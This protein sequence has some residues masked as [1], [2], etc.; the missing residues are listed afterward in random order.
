MPRLPREGALDSLFKAAGSVD[1]LDVPSGARPAA[2]ETRSAALL[3]KSRQPGAAEPQLNR[4]GRTALERELS[5]LPRPGRAPARHQ[6]LAERLAV[7]L[8]GALLR[9]H[10]RP[11]GGR[12]RLCAYRV[13]GPGAA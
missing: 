6:R 5:H 13:A 11:P 2:T 7:V 3:A 1:S 4:A 12:R 8:Q 9:P 10:Q